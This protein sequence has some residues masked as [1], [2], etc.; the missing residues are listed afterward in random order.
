LYFTDLAVVHDAAFAGLAT[1]AAP[2]IVR[3]LHAN[4]IRSGRIVELGCGSGITAAHLVSSGYDVLG[5]DASAAM[6]HLARR[7]APGASFRV[8]SVEATNIPRCV[9]VIA[10]GEV[11]T[12]LPGGIGTLRGLFRRVHAALEPGGLLIFDFIESAASRTY[13]IKAKS[14]D[15]WMMASNAT[16]DRKRRVLTRNIVVVRRRGRLVRRSSETHHVRIY[17]RRGIRALLVR[18]GFSVRLVRSYGRYRLL[19]GDVV[20]VAERV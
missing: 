10:V 12:Y 11:V 20:A 14:G 8:A 13:A 18:T 2:A 6:I 1:R 3:L 7:R 5:V 15:D 4:A 16:F 17:G 9:A 19:P